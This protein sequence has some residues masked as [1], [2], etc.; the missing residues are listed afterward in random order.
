M[1]SLSGEVV[2]SSS[3]ETFKAKVDGALGPDLVTDLVAG[4]PT[5]GRRGESK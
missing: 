4:K 5:H 3:L 1:Y 2:N